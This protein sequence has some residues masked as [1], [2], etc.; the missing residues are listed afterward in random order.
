MIY[1]ELLGPLQDFTD[2]D[3]DRPV[4]IMFGQ[5]VLTVLRIDP[6]DNNNGVLLDCGRWAETA[7]ACE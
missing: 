7:V 2:A 3:L 4:Q 5:L 6:G 1:R